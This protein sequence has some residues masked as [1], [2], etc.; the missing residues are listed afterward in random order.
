MGSLFQ[1]FNPMFPLSDPITNAV[2][3]KLPSGLRKVAN[4]VGAALNS[5]LGPQK[6]EMLID[7]LGLG[8]ATPAG[9]KNLATILATDPSNL[10][11]DDKLGG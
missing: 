3:A 6:A 8:K 7:P 11:D 5:A 9:R 10:Q 1:H 4:P 2:S